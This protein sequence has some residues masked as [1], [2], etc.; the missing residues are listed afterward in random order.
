MSGQQRLP[1]EVDPFRLAEAGRRI[2]GRLELASLKRVLPLLES[3]TADVDVNL[4]FNIDAGGIRYMHG[5]LETILALKCQRCLENMRLPVQSEFRL[6]LVEND[7]AIEQLPETYEPLLV[8]TTPI[9]LYEVLEDE[10][11]LAIPMIPMHDES[12]CSAQAFNDE[13]ELAE[14]QEEEV[15]PNPFAVLEK[16]KRD[17]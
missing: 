17:H 6:A 9:R 8:E 16:L 11:L 7:A 10:L 14:R 13:N 2:S 4:E 12:E 1:L 15:K 5:T 3:T